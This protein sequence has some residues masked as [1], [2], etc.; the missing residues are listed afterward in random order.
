MSSVLVVEDESHLAEGLRFN[1]EAEGYSVE[2]TGDGEGSLQPPV[3]GGDHRRHVEARAHVHS[4][5]CLVS[6]YYIEKLDGRRKVARLLQLGAPLRGSLRSLTV[7]LTGRGIIPAG[8]G[9]EQLR[10]TVASFPSMYQLLPSFNVSDV[11]GNPIDIFEDNSWASEEHVPLVTSARDF[12]REVPMRSSIS[13][14]SIFGYGLKTPASVKVKRTDEGRWSGF[15]VTQEASGD[16][17]VP[18]TS[19]VMPGAEIHPVRQPHGTLFVDADVKMRLKLELTRPF[20]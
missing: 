10:D 14:V 17:V 2:V 9:A 12:H 16:T 13:T 4:M 8:L 15:D 7:L 19:A 11:E 6:R 5:G 20:S 1:L 3:D 18:E